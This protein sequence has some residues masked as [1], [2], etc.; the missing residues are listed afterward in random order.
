MNVGIISAGVVVIVAAAAIIF[1]VFMRH[2]IMSA[3]FPKRSVK[4]SSLSVDQLLIR[5]YSRRDTGDKQGARRDFEE[6]LRRSP[7]HPDAATI[8]QEIAQL[9]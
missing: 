3:F 6:V 7:S 9:R 8:K 4:V 5:A 2:Q 1:L